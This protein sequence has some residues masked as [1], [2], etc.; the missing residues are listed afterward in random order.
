MLNTIH[1]IFSSSGADSSI[2]D[3]STGL[4]ALWAFE[5]DLTDDSSYGR[6]L[7]PNWYTSDV[8]ATLYYGVGIDGSC[9]HLKEQSKILNMQTDDASLAAVFDTSTWTIS[10]W[11]KQS[12]NGY[13][14]L[15]LVKDT[16]TAFDK[17]TVAMNSPGYISFLAQTTGSSQHTKYVCDDDYFQDSNWHH[18]FITRDASR[19]DFIIDNSINDYT[20]VEQP[21]ADSMDTVYV[22][23]GDG[24][25]L[26]GYSDNYYI[27]QLRIYSR[28]LTSWDASALF[29]QE[30]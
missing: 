18:I 13:G 27:D 2:V 23:N 15:I 16:A 1:G 21:L 20:I 10:A 4:E 24:N 25:S 17:I 28:K 6:D 5:N 8:G 11:V 29:N 7:S 14:P 19:F 22:G 9:V 12:A 3:T 26:E 30:I